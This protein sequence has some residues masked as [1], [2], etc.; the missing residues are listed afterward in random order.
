M[1]IATA[2]VLGWLRLRSRS[3]WPCALLHASHNLFIQAIF[4]QV[5]LPA[6]KALYLTTEFGFGL[7]IAISIAT[8]YLVLRHPL[9]SAAKVGSSI[10]A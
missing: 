4:D 3:L 10:E 2:F 5:T 9:G 8:I 6:T 7:A 1:V